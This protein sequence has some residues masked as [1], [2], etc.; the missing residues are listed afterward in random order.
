MGAGGE[1]NWASKAGQPALSPLG[2]GTSGDFQTGDFT[3]S[4][5]AEAMKSVV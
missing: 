1:P 5:Q 2:P 4:G 3:G